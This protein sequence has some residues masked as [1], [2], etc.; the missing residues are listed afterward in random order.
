MEASRGI[1]RLTY[2]LIISR[3][4]CRTTLCIW[5]Y[6]SS[7][8]NVSCTNHRAQR[9]ITMAIVLLNS[10]LAN[11][12][13]R[14]TLR[15]NYADDLISIHLSAIETPA[16]DSRLSAPEFRE[17]AQVRTAVSVM[18]AYPFTVL[19]RSQIATRWRAPHTRKQAVF[20]QNSYEHR[21]QQPLHSVL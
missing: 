3:R 16:V 14:H 5:A 7:C 17:E 6:S 2:S 1:I 12:N 10:L 15:A 13:A 18:N 21:H 20:V 19:H 4:L 11:L 8:P 9:R